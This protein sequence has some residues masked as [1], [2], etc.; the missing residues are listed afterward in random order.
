MAPDRR[1]TEP[2]TSPFSAP[3]LYLRLLKRCLTRTLFP[4]STH[5][6]DL[7]RTSPS[8]PAVRQVGGDWPTE[9][10]TMVGFER[11]DN[12]QR[13]ITTVLQDHIPGDLIETG[14]WRG[15]CGILMRA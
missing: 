11:L 13:C 10:V 14:V 3:E 8:D 4:D 6:W 5:S 15:G 7:A 2:S 12:L 1:S 9:A